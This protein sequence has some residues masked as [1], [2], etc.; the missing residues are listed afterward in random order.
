METIFLNLRNKTKA[1]YNG[2]DPLGKTFEGAIF[3]ETAWYLSLLN[4]EV[5][6]QA[7]KPILPMKSMLDKKEPANLKV[8]FLGDTFNGVGEDLLHKMILAMGFSS[9]ATKRVQFNEDRDDLN[10]LMKNIHENRPEIVV[11]LGAIVTNLLLGK[12]EKLSSIHGQLIEQEANDWKY[13]L[14]PLFHP[15][16]LLINPNMKRTAWNDLQKVMEILKK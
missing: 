8:L 16:F 3:K 14:M 2:I 7:T 12:K 13:L 15:E 10:S 11:S 1:I 4:I 6:S 9:D 5:N